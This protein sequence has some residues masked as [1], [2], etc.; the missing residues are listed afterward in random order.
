MVKLY[1][2]S[3]DKLCGTLTDDQFQVLADELEEETLEDTD[4][5]LNTATLDL[6]DE[7]GADPG[8]IVV[9]RQALAGREEMDI[10]WQRE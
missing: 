5:Y 10:R 6:L 1:D 9:L 4:Y 3:N 7:R 2:A 8:L